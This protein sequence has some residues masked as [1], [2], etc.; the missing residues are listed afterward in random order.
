MHKQSSPK[1]KIVIIL[2]TGSSLRSRSGEVQNW[3]KVRDNKSHAVI[4]V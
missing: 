2:G 1:N 4:S 3:M